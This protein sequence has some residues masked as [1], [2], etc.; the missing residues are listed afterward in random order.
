VP[1][2][3]RPHVH[4]R[5][6]QCSAPASRVG[7]VLQPDVHG[8]AS[9]S[10]THLR[11]VSDQANRAGEPQARPVIPDQPAAYVT[12]AEEHTSLDRPGASAYRGLQ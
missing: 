2:G 11:M 3:A 8:A 7:P 1:P 5:A 9:T 12:V 6:E 4:R 10:H